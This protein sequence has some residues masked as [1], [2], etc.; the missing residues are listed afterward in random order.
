MKNISIHKMYLKYDKSFLLTS[1]VALLFSFI[2][3]LKSVT[4]NDGDMVG[5][6]MW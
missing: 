3:Y 5:R 2:L 6:Y 4:H 1:V